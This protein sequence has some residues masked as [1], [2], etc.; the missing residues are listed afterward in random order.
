[1][2]LYAWSGLAVRI[3]FVLGAI[4]TV[5]QFLAVR[6]K[7]EFSARW[8]GSNCGRSRSSRRPSAR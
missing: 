3:A 2:F 8:T 6:E 1:M 5:Y 4:F 7:P